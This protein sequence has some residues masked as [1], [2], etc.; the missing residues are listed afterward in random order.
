MVGCVYSN[1]TQC[2]PYK[3]DCCEHNLYHA[4]CNDKRIEQCVC[5][6]DDRCCNE[7][8]FSICLEIAS[9][10]CQAGCFAVTTPEIATPS[11]VPAVTA[12]TSGPAVTPSANISQDPQNDQTRAV[13]IALSVLVAVFGL[14][15]IVGLIVIVLQRRVLASK[16]RRAAESL[17]GNY[18]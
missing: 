12:P 5:A 10:S 6:I 15:A 17:L 3:I 2:T 11:S 14:L 18:N 8:W 13:I 4:G 9:T 16:N 7:S 1:D